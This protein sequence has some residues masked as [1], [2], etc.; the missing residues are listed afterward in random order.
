MRPED[1]PAQDPL[2]DFAQ[3]YAAK[4]ARKGEGIEGEDI[5]YGKDPYQSVGI[6][7]PLH[8]S[9]AVFVFIHGGGWTNGYKE[10]NN[11]MAPA[12][13]SQG[14]IFVSIGYRLAPMHFFPVGLEDCAAGF[15]WVYNNISNYGGDPG[16][17]YLGGHSAGGH[18]SSLLA[19]KKDWQSAL[20]IPIETIRGCVP[21]SGVYRF[22][23]TSGLSMRPR[24]LGNE[25]N[26]NSAAASPILHIKD[27]ICPFLM[28]HGDEDFPHLVTQAKEMEEAL[29]VSGVRVD[30]TVLSNCDHFGAHYAC[31]KED[32]DWFGKILKFLAA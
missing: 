25:G 22:G 26:G 3:G 14:V 18:Y 31:G 30:R 1:Y 17:L 21:V 15:A 32:G 29:E 23:D 16:R 4:V 7:K 6:H 11:F 2:S 13:T 9:G 27:A 28:A 10:W 20:G 5:L 19:V 12:F 8:P 24:F